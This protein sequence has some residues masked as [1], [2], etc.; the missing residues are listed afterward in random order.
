MNLHEAQ[1]LALTLMDEHGVLDDGWVFRWSNGKRQLGCAQ[2]RRRT[3]RRTGKTQEIKTIKLSRY[4]VAL[5][6]EDEVRDTI[7]HEIAHAI[8][9]LKNGHNA[10]WKTVCRRIGARPERL[11]GEEVNVVKHRFEI[12]CGCCGH[13]VGKRH[14]RM[15]A[16]RLKHSYCRDCGL[17]SKGTLK[18]KVA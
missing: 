17:P 3:D 18:L 9:G 6:D 2:I 4:L 8:A 12:V 11:A 7:L 10:V 15:A 14:R 13:V 16:S 1:Q 5:N